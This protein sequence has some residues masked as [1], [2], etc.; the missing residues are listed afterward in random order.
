MF[1]ALEG[2]RLMSTSFSATT[3]VVTVTGIDDLGSQDSVTA[4]VAGGQFVVGDDGKVSSFPAAKVKKI[5]VNIRAGGATVRLDASVK[6]PS[7]IGQSPTS[8]VTPVVVYG[9]SGPDTVYVGMGTEVHG[10]S[11]NDVFVNVGLGA[12]VYGD[13]GND[14]FELTGSA[15]ARLHGGT[16]NDTLDYSGGA[17]AS[18]GPGGG[19]GILIRNGYAG[20]YS[21]DGTAIPPAENGQGYNDVY[22]GMDTF[23]G[24]QGDDFIFGTDGANY[25]DGRGGNDYVR[26]GKGDD[27]LVGGTGADALY[28]DDGNDTFYA[29]DKAKDF[30]SGGAGKDKWRG[31]ASDVLNSV[32]TKA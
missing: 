10:G 12:A 8:H 23:V 16:G 9:G 14:A 29:Q 31:D 20:E 2:R 4:K 1:E 21:Y 18:G 22:D 28:G 5:V 19:V 11:G 15:G 25:I 24:T 6:V 27:V 32:E 30:L 13:A 26:G 3:G 17:A 7:T